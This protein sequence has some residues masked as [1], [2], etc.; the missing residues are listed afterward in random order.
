MNIFYY[1]NNFEV[2]FSNTN[3]YLPSKKG[4]AI[5]LIETFLTV[6]NLISPGTISILPKFP[7]W[8]VLFCEACGIH[9]MKII[10]MCYVIKI[11]NA[12]V[13][14]FTRNVGPTVM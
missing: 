14:C 2:C 4:T 12:V 1:F 13:C 8:F 11:G 7:D 5:A 10:V 9:A 3:F 6:A